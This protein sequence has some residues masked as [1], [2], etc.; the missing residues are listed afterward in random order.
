[1]L[2]IIK[3]RKYNTETAHKVGCSTGQALYGDSALLANVDYA[4]YRKRTGEYFLHAEYDHLYDDE[5]PDYIKPLTNDEANEW[6]QEHLDAG[7]YEAEFGEV[8]EDDAN[9]AMTLNLPR[10]QYDKLKQ[11][12][13]D[14]HMPVSKYVAKLIAKI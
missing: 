14:A 12:A 10:A 8:A 3:G 6:A 4:L 9:V 1:M 7:T 5:C 13:L 11:I 2:K